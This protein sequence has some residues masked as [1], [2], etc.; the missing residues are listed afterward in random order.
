MKRL[1]AVVSFICFGICVLWPAMGLAEDNKWTALVDESG[2]VLDEI[3]QMPDRGIPRDLLESSY[4]IAVFPSTVSA[5]FGIGGKYGQGIIMVRNEETKK[6][7][8]PAI[9]NLIG[10]SFGFQIGGE[11]TDIA[12]LV[13]NRRSVDGLLKSKCKL[14]ADAAVAA[15]PVGRDAEA[16]TDAQ[17]KGG[18]LSYSRSR[19]LFAGVKLEGAVISQNAEG[20]KALYGKEIAAKDI[21]IDNKT[22]MPQSA[23][24]ILKVLNKYPFKK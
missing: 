8:S 1:V 17:L 7:S 9:F 2:K 18:I 21:L 10:A 23:E 15:G 6:W 20:N 3:Q 24:R 19:G 22:K 14:G 16:A 4:A 12:L 11:A 13:M 5:A